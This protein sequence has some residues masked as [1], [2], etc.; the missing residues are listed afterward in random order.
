MIAAF[1]GAVQ[2][3]QTLRDLLVGARPAGALSPSTGEP[4]REAVPTESLVASA[5][6]AAGRHVAV[7]R[8]G[9]PW[10]PFNL[11]VA[12]LPASSASPRLSPSSSPA[13]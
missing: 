4:L 11:Q 1:F 13:A 8:E 2:M 3:V 9:L 10:D 6:E 12:S 5:E 7:R